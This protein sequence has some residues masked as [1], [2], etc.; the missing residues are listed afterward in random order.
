M[1]REIEEKDRSAFCEMMGEFYHTPGVLHE[2]PKEHF[3]I[4]ADEILSGSQFAKAYMI[5]SDGA[6]AGYGQIS[7]TFSTEAGGMVVLLE[8]L[9]IRPQYQGKG[10][11]TSFFKEMFRIYG[12]KAARLRLEVEPNNSG[13]RRLYESLGFKRLDYESMVIDNGIKPNTK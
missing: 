12:D 1:V 5:E 4:A 9:Y 8:E 3:K 13:A 2:I 11:G 10:L 6:L 7:F